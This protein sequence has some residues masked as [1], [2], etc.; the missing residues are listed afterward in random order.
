[1]F[2][3]YPYCGA[4]V[5][6]IH[7]RLEAWM[8]RHSY[9]ADKFDCQIVIILSNNDGEDAASRWSQNLEE[10]RAFAVYLA[11][12]PKGTILLVGLGSEK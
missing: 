2:S 5:R 7:D 12:F 3:V 8:H 10:F 9:D 1:M 4:R 11:H 6:H